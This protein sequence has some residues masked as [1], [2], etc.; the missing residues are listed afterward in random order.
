MNYIDN[1]E[2]LRRVVFNQGMKA[3]MVDRRVAEPRPYCRTT[4][5]HENTPAILAPGCLDDHYMVVKCS[6]QSS[7]SWLCPLNTAVVLMLSGSIS[8]FVLPVLNYRETWEDTNIKGA[9]LPNQVSLVFIPN[10]F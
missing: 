1:T 5:A 4:R 9:L 7:D 8:K 2:V 3:G 6:A 10:A